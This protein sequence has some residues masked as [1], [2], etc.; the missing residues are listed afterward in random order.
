MPGSRRGLN[1]DL[2][3]WTEK[4]KRG[5]LTY[6]IWDREQ[7]GGEEGVESLQKGRQKVSWD[8]GPVHPHFPG[9]VLNPATLI[10]N[11]ALT[12]KGSKVLRSDP[13]PTNP[14][15]LPFLTALGGTSGNGA[16]KTRFPL[17]CLSQKPA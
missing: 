13:P 7:G 17:L 2:S 11:L 10:R 14:P 1:C 16:Y 5:I 12:N 8:Q 4:L 6:K 15:P 9:S 3:D